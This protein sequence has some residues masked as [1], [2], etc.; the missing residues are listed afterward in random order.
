MLW[1]LD[2]NTHLNT[3]ELH[4]KGMQIKKTEFQYLMFRPATFN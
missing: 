3:L 4:A 1:I 2:I